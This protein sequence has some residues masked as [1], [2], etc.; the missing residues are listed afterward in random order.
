MKDNSGLDSKMLFAGYTNGYCE[1]L[2]LQTNSSLK[3]IS[4]GIRP[5]KFISMAHSNNFSYLLVSS[6]SESAA[7]INLSNF[8]NKQLNLKNFRDIY[9]IETE[10]MSQ[11]PQNEETGNSKYK[12]LC[13]DTKSKISI[14][15]I[16][17]ENVSQSLSKS[18]FEW[19][20]NKS[21]S[22]IKVDLF[23]EFVV[24]LFGSKEFAKKRKLGKTA[25]VFNFDVESKKLY[26]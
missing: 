23:E 5:V 9:A 13:L 1:I 2:S 22:L 25:D 16:C 15:E 10:E 17:F 7:I 18:K 21:L 14:K 24:C 26:L 8:E 19:G 6:F 3:L 11:F 20:V 4:L 12:L